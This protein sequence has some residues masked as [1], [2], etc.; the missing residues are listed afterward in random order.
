MIR[1]QRVLLPLVLILAFAALTGCA[2]REAEIKVGE[3]GSLTGST[4]T[5]GTSSKNGIELFVDNLNA[6]GGI[7]GEKGPLPVGDD[8]R[9]AQGAAAAVN[10][11]IAPGRVVPGP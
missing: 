5:F 7:G 8:P 4:A 11:T 3:Y 2:K 10:Q 1:I 9:K 6:Q